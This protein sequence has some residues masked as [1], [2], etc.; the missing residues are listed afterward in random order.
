MRED[1]PLPPPFGVPAG[2][3]MSTPELL[4]AFL[5]GARA[6]TS[7]DARIEEPMLVADDHLVAIQLDVAVLLRA[8]V[9]AVA[10]AVRA[11]LCRTLEAAGMVE[12][13]RESVLAGA[14]AAEAAVPRGFEWDLWARDA[15]EARTM[16]VRRALG[17]VVGE[18][19]ADRAQAQWEIDAVLEQIE[20]DW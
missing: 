11:A 6:G 5:A 10:E 9:P 17:E 1:R 12:V 19:G 16:L 13:E 8:E 7:P 14:A 20:H 18:A 15:D 3:T 2:P 4:S